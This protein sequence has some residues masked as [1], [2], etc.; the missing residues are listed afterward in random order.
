MVFL[1]TF[2]QLGL[3]TPPT[4]PP[5]LLHHEK[6]NNTSKYKLAEVTASRPTPHA[7]TV[8]YRLGMSAPVMLRLF[9]GILY[10]QMIRLIVNYNPN[11][12]AVCLPELV[13]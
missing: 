10:I 12:K 2:S 7:L 9:A 3:Q 6:R 5:T 8:S 4:Q 11:L 1:L 13:F